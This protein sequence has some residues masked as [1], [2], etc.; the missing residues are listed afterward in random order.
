L[1][2]EAEWEYAARAGTET[3]FAFGDTIQFEKQ[4]MF[5]PAADDTLGIGGAKKSE[6]P[7]DVGK[8]EPNRF[9]L[10]DMHGNVA[11]WC[12]DWYKAGFP[13]DGPLDNPTGP[14]DGDKRVIRGGSFKDFATGV[15]SASRAGFRPGE[16]SDRVG[17]RI[18]FAPVQK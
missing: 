18:V 8:T 3:P 2:T 17:F 12:L 16:R 15:R 7:Q 4:G 1:P 10:F 9:G 5:L 11:E 13:G 14:S 6:F